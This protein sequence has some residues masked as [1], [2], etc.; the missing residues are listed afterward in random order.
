MIISTKSSSFAKKKKAKKWWCFKFNFESTQRVH[1]IVMKT[2]VMLIF[3]KFAYMIL[4]SL[5]IC[6]IL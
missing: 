4:G 2:S 3:F 5:A 6:Q 1:K